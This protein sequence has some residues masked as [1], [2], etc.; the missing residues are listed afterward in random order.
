MNDWS[1][2]DQRLLAEIAPV[3]GALSDIVSSDRIM[4]VGAQ[5]R[6][7]L[8]WRHG[9]GP[10]LRSTNDTDVALALPS[11]DEFGLL[12]R[13]FSAVGDSGHRYRIG[14]IV[15]DVI[16]FGGVEAPPGTTNR[17]PGKHAM[18]V[19]GFTDAYERTDQLPMTDGT[20][21]R[22]PRPEGF[23]VLKAHAWLD[24]S[25]RHDFDLIEAAAALL[26]RDMLAA[27]SATERALL[28]TRIAGANRDLLANN[29]GLG[30]PGWPRSGST[31]RP[32]VDALFDELSRGGSV[33]LIGIFIFNEHVAILNGKLPL[34]G[35]GCRRRRITSRDKRK[36]GRPGEARA[37]CWDPERGLKAASFG[38][39]ACGRKLETAGNE[40]ARRDSN[41]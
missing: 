16:A 22:I 8:D 27:L 4:L 34:D 17:P 19:H 1:D 36:P 9:S 11:W 39:V 7:L 10:P 30:R 18:N 31:R 35:R 6:N 5:C 40:R 37:V 29:L 23:A 41:P 38:R 2:A 26:G 28:A 25:Q 24:R 13:H 3:V 20:S 14:G 32:I 33:Q 12:R 15:T 21:I